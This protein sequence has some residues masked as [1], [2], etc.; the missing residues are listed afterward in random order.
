MAI[1]VVG[2]HTRNLGKTSVVAAIIARLPEMRWTAMKITQYGHGICSANGEPCD[3]ATDDHTIAITAE[4]DPETG[5]DSAR[6]LKAGAVRSLWVRT[7]QG[8]LADA[9]PGV[10]K[11]IARAENVIIESN[12]VMQF[13]RPDLFLSV[14]DYA[15]AD[16]K[17]SALRALDR[18]DAILLRASGAKLTPQ[19]RGVS[20]KLFVEKLMFEI[21]PPEYMTDAVEEFVRERMAKAASGPVTLREKQSRGPSLRSG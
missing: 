11:E 18:A 19:W 13:L 5:T 4:R 9:M 16:F 15:T 14:L 8:S 10:R 6:F 3:C 2:G 12:S 20:R 17:P 21:G 1:V 7:R